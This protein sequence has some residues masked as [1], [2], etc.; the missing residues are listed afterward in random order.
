[1]RCTRDG[2][3]CCGFSERIGQNLRI[4]G[5]APVLVM[6]AQHS[7][8]FERKKDL[9]LDRDVYLRWGKTQDRLGSRSLRCRSLAMRS[10]KLVFGLLDESR[11]VPALADGV[12]AGVTFSTMASAVDSGGSDDSASDAVASGGIAWSAA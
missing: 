11:I 12:A 8:R 5:Q 6:G 10:R 3:G 7:P 4:V 1:M 2:G 9:L